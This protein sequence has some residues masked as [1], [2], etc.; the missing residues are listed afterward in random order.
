MVATKY[1][2]RNV[3]LPR[4]EESDALL[5][6]TRGRVEDP[7]IASNAAAL[8]EALAELDRAHRESDGRS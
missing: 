5:A 6:A 2:W 7:A 4:I 1:C 3:A 8:E